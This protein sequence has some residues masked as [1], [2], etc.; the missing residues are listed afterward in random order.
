MDIQLFA[1]RNQLIIECYRVI[2]L[3]TN[4]SNHLANGFVVTDVD[5]LTINLL[6]NSITSISRI[7]LELTLNDA[8]TLEYID[9]KAAYVDVAFK[10]IPFDMRK[11]VF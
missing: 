8:I 10:M 11:Q 4:Y 7:F 6:E 3:L 9:K 2:E 1:R 5:I